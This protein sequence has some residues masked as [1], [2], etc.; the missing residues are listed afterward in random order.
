MRGQKSNFIDWPYREGLRLDEAM[1]PL[2]MMATGIY[3]EPMANQNGAPIRL[4]VPWK[5]GYK[6][7]KSVVKIKRHHLGIDQVIAIVA[8]AGDAQ[9]EGQLGRCE[10]RLWR[11]VGISRWRVHE[12]RLRSPDGTRDT[13]VRRRPL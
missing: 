4:V 8:P 1:N 11:N 10:E 9:R 13:P 5:Y 6:S 2:T 3:D 12:R 7:I